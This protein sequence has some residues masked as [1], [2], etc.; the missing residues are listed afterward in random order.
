MILDANTKTVRDIFEAGKKYI[1]PRNQREYSWGKDELQ[2]LWDDICEN[3]KLKKKSNNKY[4]K[5]EYFIGC[6]VLVGK[7]ASQEMQIVD[8]QQRLTTL[9]IF[10]KSIVKTFIDNGE[11]KSASALYS[12][13]I[14]GEDDDGKPYFKLINETPKPFFQKEIQFKLP[15]GR[16]RATTEEEKKLQYAYDFFNK[17][18]KSFSLTG[19]DYIGSIKIL[20]DQILDYLKFIHVRTESE[21]DAYTIFETLNARGLNLSSVD[22]IKNWIFKN[23][24]DVHPD[25]DAKTIWN[26]IKNKLK[27]FSDVEEFFR[28]YWNS[29][30]GHASEDR[31][32]KDFKKI[33]RKSII[34]DAKLFLEELN[35]ASENYRKIGNPL[36]KDWRS[37]KEKVVVKHFSLINQYRVTQVRPFLLSLIE[38]R[39]DKKTISEAVF[40]KTVRNLENFHFIF[41]SLCQARAS[42]LEGKY[43]RAAKKLM[44][45]SKRTDAER[46]VEELIAEL[47]AKRPSIIEVK[48]SLAGL[49][50]SNDFDG[51][52][53]LIQTIFMKIEEFLLGRE[54]SDSFSLEHVSDQSSSCKWRYE[55]KNIIPLEE[56]VN[57]S[58]KSGVSFKDKKKKYQNSKFESVKKFLE[59]NPQDD[60][61]EVNADSWLDWIA[62]IL[63]NAT[64]LK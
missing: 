16:V 13:L 55:I 10:L 42:G 49:K 33:V 4:D 43:N 58:I 47:I 26:S 46:V 56:V 17:R 41:S 18:L 25:D 24:A 50:F 6:I 30:Y 34:T 31:L 12:N 22:L 57:N 1:V 64:A 44:L 45:T 54:F 11:E 20:R 38:C 35:A 23:Y 3:I 37:A 28:H 19:V 59:K 8:G 52:K 15:E 32:Y 53:K 27:G 36:S 61:E 51:N 48:K 9:T 60:W 2:D 21:D 62:N 40:L 14:E 7:D 63:D 39:V 5:N 29:K